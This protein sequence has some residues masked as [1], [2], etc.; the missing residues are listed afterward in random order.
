MS[1]PR[2][3][4]DCGRQW[5][6]Q[7]WSTWADLLSFIARDDIGAPAVYVE[8]ARVL[9]NALA[10][11]QLTVHSLSIQLFIS[12]VRWGTPDCFTSTS[13]LAQSSRLGISELEIP[14]IKVHVSQYQIRG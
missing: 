10:L 8:P 7:L 2:I 12:F 3:P 5:G 13:S 9:Q 1:Y 11:D 6:K 14:G 4:E